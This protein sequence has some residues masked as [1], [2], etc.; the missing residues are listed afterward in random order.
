MSTAIVWFRRDLRLADHAALLAALDAA[1]TVIPVYI[2]SPDT[3]RP[4]TPGGASRWWLHHSLTA[5]DV[6]LQ[7]LGSRLVIREG[8]ELETLRQ[9]IAETGASRVYWNR[10]YSPGEITRDTGIKQALREAGLLVETFNGSLL[11]EPWE[12]RR[13]G[14]EPYRVFTPFWKAVQAL[15]LNRAPEPAP[16]ALPRLPAG[17]RSLPLAALELLPRIPWDTGLSAQWAPG[18]RSAATRLEDFTRSALGAYKG[19][20]DVPAESGTSRLSPYLHF[21]EISPRQIVSRLLK[22]G[23]AISGPGMACYIRELGWREFACHLL[24]HFPHTAE[25]PLDDRFLR[26]PWRTEYAGDLRLW[27]QG[28]TGF[29]IID[30]G[31]R[32]LW[33]TGWMHNRVRMIAASLLT[34]N[35]LIPWQEG[36]AWF[37][38]TLVDADLASNSLGWQWTAGCGADAAPYFRIFNPVLQGE[39]FDPAG[40]YVRRWIPEL[41]RLPAKII[42][43]PWLSAGSLPM[44]YGVRLGVDYPSPIVDLKISRERALTAFSAIKTY[45]PRER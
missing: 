40:E 31:M 18:E 11:Y 24:F 16:G 27:Q 41:A 22:G 17:I 12:V 34:K 43:Q 9:L 30:A 3:G 1:I 25:Q 20:R 10:L 14:G 39:R 13:S 45:V 15:G 26:L 2:H 36:A 23:D 28:R 19:G 6:S 44:D 32:E 38:D 35:L 42:H 29:P 8:D 21:G 4:W 37:W 7:G 5:L 33:R